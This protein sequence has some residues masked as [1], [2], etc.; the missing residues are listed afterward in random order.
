ML[1]FRF[2]PLAWMAAQSLGPWRLY[3]AMVLLSAGAIAQQAH[4]VTYYVDSANGQDSWSG[5]LQAP[6]GSLAT[7]GPWQSLAK[8]GSTVLQPGDVVLLK[9][10]QT[11][12]ET[13][14]L[15]SN[16]TVASPIQIGRY[17]AGCTNLPTIDGAMPIP[18][19]S[20]VS[21]ERSIFRAQM[22]IDLFADAP[23]D[24]GTSGWG[25]WS[26]NGDATIQSTSACAAS[27]P[28]CLNI[29][30]GAGKQTISYS[31]RVPMYASAGYTLRF[32]AKAPQGAVFRVLIRRARQ[33]WQAVGLNAAITGTGAWAS[34]SFAVAPTTSLEDAYVNFEV[35]Q[36][37]VTVSIDNLAL[38][39]ASTS[40]AGVFSDNGLLTLAHH[41]NAGH[42]ASDPQSVFFRLSGDSA[43]SAGGGSGILRTG[44][45]FNSVSR[46]QILPGQTV[47]LRA[48]PWRMNQRQ[49]TDF[50][51]TSISFSPSSSYPLLSRSGFFLTGARWMLDEP[52]E[53]FH[54]ASAKA[55]SVWMPDGQAPGNR[56]SVSRLATAV[57]LSGRSYIN[58]D[59]IAVRRSAVGLQLTGTNNVAVRNSI[60]SD[61][62]REGIDISNAR[63]LV[64]ER[65]SI[66]RTGGDAIWRS[67]S[68]VNPLYVRVSGNYISQSGVLLDTTGP[69]NLPAPSN[70]AV[71]AGDQAFVWQNIIDQAGFHGIVTGPGSQITAN[72]VTGACILLDD[73]GGI[74]MYGINSG[75]VTGNLVL[76]LA[77]NPS[78]N[79]VP[80]TLTAGIYLDELSSNLSIRGNAVSNAGYGIM[81][82]DAANNLVENNTLYGNSYS[83]ILLTETS[84]VIRPTGDIFGNVVR[85]N[86]FFSATADPAV[87][88]ATLFGSVAGFATYDSNVHSSL[89]GQ[90]VVREANATSDLSYAFE[91]WRA[92]LSGGLPRNLEPNGRVVA[93][94]GYTSFAIAGANMLPNGDLAGSLAGWKSWNLTPPLATM[95]F[96]SDASRRW[97]KYVGGASS[98]LFYPDNFS[99]VDGQWYRLSFDMKTNVVNQRV[100]LGLK[101]GGGGNNLYE[102]LTDAIQYVFGTTNWRRYSVMF[103]A[104]KTVNY[105]DPATSDW[106]A[107]MEFQQILPGQTVYLSRAELVPVQPVGTTLR[108]AMLS[109]PTLFATSVD[110]PDAVAYPSACS[111]FV[112]FKDQVPIVWPYNLPALGAE[113]IYTRDASLVDFDSD[114]IADVQDACPATPPGEAVNSRGCGVSQ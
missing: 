52:G 101:R 7:D 49:V 45:D 104:N 50:D 39:L 8:V 51:G 77:G 108:T 73:C 89:T 107:R 32:M 40:V 80:K 3:F 37:G 90:Y 15:L 75:S 94:V 99:V 19:R 36:G 60:V 53:W 6:S 95:T 103:K 47:H 38:E 78:G 65:N 110:C 11:W 17:P 28:P 18:A 72:V 70:G 109:N 22:A 16:G 25:V 81:L 106:G 102:L 58:I 71:Q 13:L 2:R 113:I 54:D 93:P 87:F 111:Q 59:G 33:P 82:H 84:R 23:L 74:Y 67:S 61:T 112:R 4:A 43:I 24:A 27:A 96:E 83:Q 12:R 41:P 31:Y 114:G 20:F 69:R 62:V 92:T 66:E 29:T 56:I 98:S 79:P 97:I 34:Y 76:D 57:D 91:P 48:R 63:Y 68:Y 1:T 21:E 100:G 55:L 5:L 14:K 42:D 86:R 85:A 64:I 30:S 26:T 10:G 105:R 46:G 44:A 9:C 35:P 88:Q